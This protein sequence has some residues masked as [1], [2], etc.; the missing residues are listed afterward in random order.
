MMYEK[1]INEFAFEYV[2]FRIVWFDV[3]DY[4]RVFVNVYLGVFLYILSSGLDLLMKI[5]D[6]FGVLLFVVVMWYVVIG[7]FV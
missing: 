7:E 4:S 6:M 2:A 5:V 1:K 3:V